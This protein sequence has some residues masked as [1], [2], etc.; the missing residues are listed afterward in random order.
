MTV[1]SMSFENS[2]A[3]PL[4][5]IILIASWITFLRQTKAN[6]D[7]L[8]KVISINLTGVFLCMYYLCL[9]LYH[10]NYSMLNRCNFSCRGTGYQYA[11]RQMVKQGR[12]GRII[13]ASSIAGKKGL[14]FL[15]TYS[16]SKFA[17][18]GLTQSVGKYTF[19]YVLILFTISFQRGRV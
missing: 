8:A 1:C 18:R 15:S 12:G 13:G 4:S 10:A 11:A 14:P 7:T 3:L 6:A 5:P 2:A 16:A 9:Y 17:V 19:L